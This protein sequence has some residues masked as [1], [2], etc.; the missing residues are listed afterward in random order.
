MRSLGSFLSRARVSR[1]GF[2]S[3]GLGRCVLSVG[4]LLFSLTLSLRSQAF[5]V[6]AEDADRDGVSDAMEAALLERFLPKFQVSSA[7]CGVRPAEFVAGEARARTSERNGT[8]YGQVTPRGRLDSG[9]ALIELHYFD[10]WDVDCGQNGHPLDAEH[11][12]VLLRAPRSDEGAGEWRAMYWFAS[13]HAATV[14]DTSQMATGKALRA[15]DKGA[16]VWVSPGKHAAYLNEAICNGG[17]GADRC[18]RMT[19]LAVKQVVNLGEPN[20]LMSGALWVRD[21]RWAMAA[22]MGTDFSPAVMDRMARGNYGEPVQMNGARPSVKSSI[23]VANQTYGGIATGAAH[24]GAALGTADTETEAALGTATDRTGG[25][26]GKATHRTEG[27]LGTA[28]D[29]T[30]KA[31]EKSARGVGKALGRTGRWVRGKQE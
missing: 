9:E 20:A 8:V 7:D 23:Y 1:G 6:A 11:V 18:E 28:T 22:K 27:S 17:C 26:L 14:C 25:A 13:A 15:E 12:G 16:Q 10:L 5:H 4:S 24:T 29:E 2:C 19:P 21:P 30:G 31:L 3:H